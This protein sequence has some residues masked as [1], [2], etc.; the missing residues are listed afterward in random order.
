MKKMCVIYLLLVFNIVINGQILDKNPIP[1]NDIAKGLKDFNFLRNILFN[2]GLTFDSNQ[3]AY[4]TQPHEIWSIK[5]KV[6]NESIRNPE[7]NP[8]PV[9]KFEFF[10]LKTPNDTLNRI[11]VTLYKE[12][13][14][15]YKEKFLEDIKKNLP[16]QQLIQ[17]FDG[18]NQLIGYLSRLTGKNTNITVL[19]QE[20]DLDYSFI[21]TLPYN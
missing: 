20:Y 9:I 16:D 17:K 2:Y 5:Q 15:K 1:F 6:D 11:V 7:F 8:Y 13:F 3:S 21:F 19:Y 14:S 10:M 12:F 4:Y 18:N